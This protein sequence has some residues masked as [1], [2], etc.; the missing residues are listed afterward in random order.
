VREKGVRP[1]IRA[2]LEQKHTNRMMSQIS[3]ACALDYRSVAVM[4]TIERRV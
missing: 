2:G 3:G 1:K 4:I